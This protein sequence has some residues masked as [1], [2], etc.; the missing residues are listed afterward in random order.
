MFNDISRQLCEFFSIF[1][2]EQIAAR[3][4]LMTA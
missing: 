4:N 1:K 3:L 2:K